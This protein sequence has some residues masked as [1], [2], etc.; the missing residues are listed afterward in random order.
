MICD[1]SSYQGSVD[2]K[3]L[4]EKV[5]FLILR[6]S[7]GLKKDTRYLEYVN[8]CREFRIPYHAYRFLKA[9]NEEEARTEAKIFAQSTGNTEPLFYVIDAEYSGIKANNARRICEVFEEALRHYASDQIKVAVYIGHHLYKSWNLDYDRYAYVWIPRYSNSKKPDYPC[10]IWQYTSTGHVD[11][12][13]GNVDLNVLNGNK[14]LSYFTEG[15]G[16]ET[17]AKLMP[18]KEFV[19]ELEAALK[20]KDGYI[21]GSRGENPRTGYLDLSVP[22]SKCRSSWKPEGYYFKGQYS[23]DKLKKALEWRKNCTR[24]WDCNGM[25]EGI[26]ELYSGVNVNTRARH[27]Y[28]NWCSIKGKGI[29]PTKYRVPGAAVYFSDNGA[30]DIHHVAYLYKPVKASDPSGDWYLIE[31]SGVMKGVVKSKLLSRKPNF[32]GLMDKYFDY[33][34]VSSPSS[35]ETAIERPLLGSRTLKNGSEGEDVKELQSGLIRLGYDLGK[36]GADGDFGDCTEEAVATF[37]SDHGLKASGKFDSSTFKVFET[38]LSTIDA[39]ADDPKCVVIEGGN[40]N[41][42]ETP[43]VEGKRLG[44]AH[45]GDRYDFGGVI[46]EDT[47]WLSI[48]YKGKIAWVSYKYGRLSK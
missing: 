26:Y 40:C 39:P 30:S 22:E 38:A 47:G 19:S 12:I 46:D 45:E 41:I 18:S 29:I 3:R 48:V 7:V 23:G 36:W 28:A 20:R 10:D 1:L 35:E 44:V 4:S 31:A 25:S 11:G 8:G 27:S 21:M 16:G 42:R 24:V 6:A 14:P 33:G 37:Q 5:D 9:T 15:F 43:G 32:W 13:N 34:D 17:M 2:F